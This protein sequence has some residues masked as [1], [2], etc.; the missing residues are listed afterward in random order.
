M[1]VSKHNLF[2]QKTYFNYTIYKYKFKN[3]E[4]KENI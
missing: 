1:L 3:Y 4:I 2:N